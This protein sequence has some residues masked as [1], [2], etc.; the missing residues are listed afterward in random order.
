MAR[1]QVGYDPRAEALQT[2]AA[3]NIQTVQARQ[4][5]P[6]SSKAFQLAAAL[7]AP[8]VQQGLSQ[9]SERV[10]ENERD[11]AR[12]YAN[13]MT[14]E[15]L[16]KQ[17]K[18]GKI[19]QSQSPA[20]VATVQHIY[21]ENSLAGFERDTISKMER[22]ELKFGSQEELDKYLT[23]YRNKALG[24]QSDY[25]VAG[26]DKKWN[27]F[28]ENLSTVNTRILDKNFV[29]QGS[30]QAQDNLTTVLTDVKGKSP[31]EGA[32]AIVQRY[33]LLRKTSLLKDDQGREALIGVMTQAAA[34][35]NQALVDELSK[36]KLDNGVTV[37]AVVGAKTMVT[38]SNAA[39]SMLDKNERQRV[40]VEI[41]PFLDAADKGELTGK[42]A[43]EFDSWIKANEKYVSSSTIH[44]IT[45][46]QRAAEARAANEA[47]KAKLLNLA[48]QSQAA[49][50]QTVQATI[51]QG[52]FAF[53]PQLKVVSPTTGELVDMDQK[54]FATEYV[55]KR[56]AETNMPLDKQV[57]YWSTNGLQN[58]DWK[59]QVQAGVSNI[60]SVG[61]TY[62]G[63]NVGQLNPQGQAAIQRYMEIAAV[64]PAEADKYAGSKENQ[65]L[66]SDIK[67][68]MEKGGMPNVSDAAAFVNQANRRGIEQK[69]SAVKSAEIKGAVDDIVNPSM[70]SKPV[71]WVKTLFGGNENVNLT[72][73]SS[74]VRRRAELLVQSGQVTDAK[75]AVQASVEYFAN[76]A[77]TSKINNTLY[78]NKDLPAV[79]KGENP[80]EWMEKFITA[81]PGKI[82]TDQK[83]DGSRVRLEPN[84]AGGFTAWIGGVPLTDDKGVV[85]TYTKGQISEWISGTY[86]NDL[87]TKV[88]ETNDKNAFENW[89]KRVVAEYYKN[90]QG[91]AGQSSAALTYL[92]SRG[93]YEYF[94]QQG[95][96]DK[97]TSELIEIIKK[98]GK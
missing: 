32:A 89:G 16:G 90:N 10:N 94:R 69:D 35:G 46:G 26:F 81:Q 87:R 83:L 78:F 58:P 62:D 92:T 49:A 84:T 95:A 41:R 93:A 6:N 42:K 22:G 88:N 19:L 77:V 67:F 91:L 54:K 73:I 36:I 5:D 17:I 57:Q 66:L 61:W 82:A 25:T 38:I 85:Q 13:S 24:G 14:V 40:D 45:N 27:Q 31:T 63:K 4:A 60:A 71:N 48:E 34:D 72:A 51:E 33:Q 15:E 28:R 75:A 70:F 12:A 1:V 80:G 21:G 76:P 68:M 97:P 47:N 50:Q 64:N 86:Q 11:K 18:E 96:L 44:A 7:G 55:Q 98:K 53:L 74:D 2:T 56:I 65:R 39:Q 30:Q 52:G 79:P 9:L 29:E 43:E 37:G 8:S 3:P 59:K 20:Y 23:D